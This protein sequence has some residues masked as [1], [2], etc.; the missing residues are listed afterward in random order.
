MISLE[1]YHQ[2][3]TYDT[4]NNLTNLSHQANSSAWQQT[5]AIHPNNNRGTETQQSATD[6]DANGNLLG[7]N[8]IGN[9]E[10]HYNNTLN[11]LIKADKTNA[12]EYCV[13][14]Y[15]GNRV[16]SVV[17]FNNQVQNQR[18]YLPS[19]DISTNRAKQQNRTIHIGSHILSETSKD[20]AP[21]PTQNLTQTRYQLTSHL[22]SST[23]ELNDKAQVVSYEHYY[24]YGGTALIAGKDKTEVQQKRYRY[25]DKERDDNSGLYYYGARYLAPWLARWI[26]PDS[27]GADGLNLYVY[28]DNNPLKYIDPTGHVKVTSVN[29]DVEDYEIDILSPIRGTYQ[30]SNLFY[31][32]KSYKRL[33]KIVRMYPANKFD[34]LNANTTFITMSEEDKGALRIIARS[35]PSFTSGFENIMDFTTGQLTFKSNFRGKDCTSGLNATEVI[36]YQ[37]LGMTKIA[38]A[39]NMLP[40][41]FLREGISNT[42]AKEAIEIYKADGDYPKFY[43]NFVGNS[44]NGRSSLRLANTFSLKITSIKLDDTRISAGDSVFLYL[45]PKMPLISAEKP[46]PP[47]GDM[48]DCFT[49]DSRPSRIR[50]QTNR[51]AIL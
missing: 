44:D 48:Q 33:E 18:D 20:K 41:T 29:M 4:G 28:V 3:Y 30:N 24:P 40:Q 46:L 6:F 19:L 34:T 11:K 16:R 21:N 17:E 27:Q 13:Y 25:T 50:R 22:Q 32:P 26:S 42:S 35:F 23:L 45:K 38:G 12:T 9:L 5:I 1:S 31:F 39:L 51:C 43:R 36:S 14:D 7:L 37:Y 47:R 2:T 10:W 15:Q 49:P 8:N